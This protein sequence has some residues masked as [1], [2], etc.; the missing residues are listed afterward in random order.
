M[1]AGMLMPKLAVAVLIAAWPG[2]SQKWTVGAL[3]GYPHTSTATVQQGGEKTRAG[4]RQG[5]LVGFQAGQNR[6]ERLGGEFR[7]CYRFS[8]F[9][10]DAGGKQ[11]RF[12]GRAHLVHYDLLFYAGRQ[13]AKA[14]PYLAAGGGVKIYQGTG[15][16]QAY[17][18]L[19]SFAI[20]TRT[21]QVVGMASFGGGVRVRLGQRG[22]LRWEVRDYLTPVPK[23]VIA[24]APGAQI[25]GWLHDIA[26]V[27]AIGIGF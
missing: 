24:P 23:A 1:R 9:K 27:A 26:P 17:Q 4:N 8:D 20:L 14:R 13:H 11:V 7:Y 12:A 18:P 3:A 25:G 10:L 2:L 22:W 6:Y 5:V 16:E 21:R 19:S 15:E